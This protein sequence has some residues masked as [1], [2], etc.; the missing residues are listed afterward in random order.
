[1]HLTRH[2]TLT[3]ELLNPCTNTQMGSVD[4]VVN[5]DDYCE[6]P[7]VDPLYTFAVDV[8]GKA[9][10]NGYNNSTFVYDSTHS[11]YCWCIQ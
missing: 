11:P 8:S 3:T 4:F 9:I 2:G 6:T 1:M 7:M 5:E 10:A